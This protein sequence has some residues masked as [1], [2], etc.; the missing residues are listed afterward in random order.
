MSIRPPG[1]THKLLLLCSF[2]KSF[3]LSVLHLRL[4]LLQ[5]L[6]FTDFIFSFTVSKLSVI[7]LTGVFSFGAF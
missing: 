4:F 5:C 7:D 6:H 1:I 2:L 3:F